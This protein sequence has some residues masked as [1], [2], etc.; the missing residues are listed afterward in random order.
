MNAARLVEPAPERPAIPVAEDEV[1]VRIL[2]SDVLQDEGF[3]VLEAADAREAMRVLE[4]R[5]DVHVVVT[6]VEMPPGPSGIELA[7]Q[8]RERWPYIQVLVTSGRVF[9]TQL[10]EETVFVPKPW[11]AESLARLVREAVGR[12]VVVLAA[13]AMSPSPRS[14]PRFM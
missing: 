14:P 1:L 3:K 4:A 8:V 5:P 10:P 6:D 11:T 12:P 13:E 7:Q 9:P 2:I